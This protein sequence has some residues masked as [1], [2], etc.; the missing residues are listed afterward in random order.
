M[1]HCDSNFTETKDLTLAM[2]IERDAITLTLVLLKGCEH[3]SLSRHMICA[4]TIKHPTYTTGG[5]S[6]KKQRAPNYTSTN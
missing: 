4:S 6:L 5:V 3:P 2:V 1:F